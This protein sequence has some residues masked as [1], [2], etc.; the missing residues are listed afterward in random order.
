MILINDSHKQTSAHDKNVSV[1][2]QRH[3]YINQRQIVSNDY[4]KHCSNKYCLQNIVFF[5]V[6]YYNNN[7]K[8]LSK[9]SNKNV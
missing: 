9:N 4:F 8:T 3:V 7:R 5:D 1:N 6:I 2:N